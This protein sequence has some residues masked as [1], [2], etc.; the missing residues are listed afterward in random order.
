VQRKQRSDTVLTYKLISKSYRSIR[1]ADDDELLKVHEL[2]TAHGLSISATPAAI[3]AFGA[4]L[5]TAQVDWWLTYGALLGIV[6]DKK[7]MSWDNDVDLMLAPGTD[8]ALVHRVLREAGATPLKAYVLED[9][10]FCEK[11]WFK[12]T[13]FDL[14]YGQV[15]NG[16]LVDLARLRHCVFY[17]EHDLSGV[18]KLE[19]EGFAVNVPKNAEVYLN[20]VYGPNWRVPNPDWIWH[21][22][23][24]V[25]QISGPMLHL[26]AMWVRREILKK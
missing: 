20:Q 23:Q 6:R 21:L 7:F 12:N 3:A 19:I 13:Y 22:Q 8:Q 25:L 26:I 14:Y 24:P 11:F 9:A 15:L 16:K 5:D 2:R 1:Y 17:L 18:E 4:I 10:V